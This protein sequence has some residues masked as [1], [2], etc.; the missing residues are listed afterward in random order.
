MSSFNPHLIDYTH[1]ALDTLN[2]LSQPNLNNAVKNADMIYYHT[3]SQNNIGVAPFLNPS[4]SFSPPCVSSDPLLA[5]YLRQ[6]TFVHQ[7]FLYSHNSIGPRDQVFTS[8]TLTHEQSTT[9]TS[10]LLRRTRTTNPTTVLPLIP[11]VIS[12]TSTSRR[13]R[14]LCPFC[15]KGCG[16]RPRAWTCFFNHIGTKPFVCNGICGTIG[17]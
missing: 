9:P 17:W 8:D 5:R 14:F 12:T 4:Q 2:D 6:P 13:S 11:A 10:A 3:H 15:G 16:S 7:P 1:H